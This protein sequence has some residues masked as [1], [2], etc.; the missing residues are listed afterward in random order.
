MEVA[1]NDLHTVAEKLQAAP[2][3]PPAPVAE[4]DL[5]GGWGAP[6]PA[7]SWG[8][9]TG[10]LEPLSSGD[11]DGGYHPPVQQFQQQMA[12][13]TSSYDS[14]DGFVATAPAP[15]PNNAA[16]VAN[17]AYGQPHS[18]APAAIQAYGQD[19]LASSAAT[20]DGIENAK[21]AALAAETKAREADETYRALSQETESLRKVSDAAE[22]EAMAKQEKASSKKFGKKKL[23]KEAEEAS[24]EAANKKKHFLEMQ[25]Q[26][27]NAQSL[28]AASRKEAD[29]LRN[30]A[31]QAELDFASAES[32]KDSGPSS[33]GQAWGIPDPPAQS[34]PNYGIDQSKASSAFGSNQGYGNSSMPVHMVMQPNVSQASDDSQ[35]FG[36]AIMGGGS[37]LS[38][39]TPSA[40]NDYNYNNPF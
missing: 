1:S 40:A 34:Y 11:D 17:Q 18:A 23:M 21:R 29:K 10:G 15:A 16:P 12:V 39:P 20:R 8:T 6:A 14:G 36:G 25:A 9:S 2:A 13:S 7:A 24:I 37:G 4:E 22:A 19:P 3:P 32:A 5:F 30:F 28:A 27:S 38:I 33:N 26:T 31:E 35:S